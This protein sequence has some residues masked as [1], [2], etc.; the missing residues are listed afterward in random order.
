[1]SAGVEYHSVAPQ[2]GAQMMILNPQTGTLMSQAPMTAAQSHILTANSAQGLLPQ[3]QA[4]GLLG[5]QTTAGGLMQNHTG[6][7]GH[8]PQ[9][10]LGAPLGAT[11]AAPLSIT[12]IMPKVP[13]MATLPPIFSTPQFAIDGELWKK[14]FG[15]FL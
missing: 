7:L 13:A 15:V 10:M 3:A 4:A 14:C 12:R 2:L 5:H 8:Q 6:M 9:G 11:S 1:M